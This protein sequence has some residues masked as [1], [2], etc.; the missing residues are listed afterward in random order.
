MVHNITTSQLRISKNVIID[1]E[2]RSSYESPL[3]SAR[4]IKPYS[5][6]L[7]EEVHM[8][9]I[10]EVETTGTSTHSLKITKKECQCFVWFHFKGPKESRSVQTYIA[11]Q[12]GVPTSCNVIGSQLPRGG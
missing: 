9:S 7:M 12:H 10:G 1:V 8:V 6:V 4:F 11:E 5:T 3:M 2:E